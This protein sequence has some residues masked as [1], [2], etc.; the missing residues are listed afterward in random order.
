MRLVGHGHQSTVGGANLT[1]LR[2]NFRRQGLK[3]NLISQNCVGN[4]FFADWG[5]N[6]GLSVNLWCDEQSAKSA[7]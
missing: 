7:Q 5:R 3:K 2:S 4:I 1:A 6:I